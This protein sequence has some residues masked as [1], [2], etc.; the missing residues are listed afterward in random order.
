VA[1]VLDS[2]LSS[3]EET[4]LGTFLEG[5]AIHLCQIANPRSR[6]CTTKGIDLEFESHGRLYLVAIKSGPNWGNSSQIRDM[7]KSFRDAERIYKQ[8]KGSLPVEFINGCCYGRT[9]VAREYKNGY[10]KVCGQRFWELITGDPELYRTIIEPI[11]EDARTRNLK[12]R[13]EYEKVVQDFTD[14]F[15]GSFCADGLIQWQA[16]AEFIS[17]AK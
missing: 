9:I 12:F 1:A 3:Q 14:E 6:K 11:G 5:L 2:H 16:L 15:R 17:A 8:S 4:L 7:L 10:R 13:S